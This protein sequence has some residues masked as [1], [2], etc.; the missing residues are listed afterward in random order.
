MPKPKT[1]RDIKLSEI[2]ASFELESYWWGVTWCPAVQRKDSGS[3][4][5]RIVRNRTLSG[6]AEN[7]NY[8][9]FELDADGLISIAP[10]G[11]ARQFK[12]CRVVDIEA[13]A[14]RFAE[15]AATA[16]RFTLGGF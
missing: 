2:E 14:D 13:A 1:P 15:P 4:V 8:D 11:Y 7:V 3:Y 6:S 12:P 5:I 9:F 16:R 10:R